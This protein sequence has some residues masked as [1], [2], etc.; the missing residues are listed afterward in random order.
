MVTYGSVGPRLSNVIVAVVLLRIPPQ[1]DYPVS[2]VA[3]FTLTGG[4][5]SGLL[6]G[7]AGCS[8]FRKARSKPSKPKASKT[9]RF[10]RLREA[11]M[12]KSGW[13]GNMEALLAL[14]LQ[15]DAVRAATYTQKN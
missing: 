13:L 3:R 1:Q 12:T 6:R 14:H 2:I 15:G 8:C 10:I 7:T 11:Q 5:A 4:T 9:T